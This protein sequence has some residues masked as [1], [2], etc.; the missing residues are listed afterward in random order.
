MLK[1]PI[2]NVLFWPTVKKPKMFIILQVEEAANPCILDGGGKKYLAFF[3]WK[4]TD[5]LYNWLINWSAQSLFC[6]LV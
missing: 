4:I 5:Q 2:A 3:A 6:A 1:V